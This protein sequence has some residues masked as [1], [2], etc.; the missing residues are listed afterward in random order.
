MYNLY[1][2]CI[3]IIIRQ[4]TK[5]TTTRRYLQIF[6]LFVQGWAPTRYT[7]RYYIINPYKWPTNEW[8]NWGYDL[9][10]WSHLLPL[11]MHHLPG[12]GFRVHRVGCLRRW[13]RRGIRGRGLYPRGWSGWNPGPGGF[14]GAFWSRFCGI[15][16]RNSEM[17]GYCNYSD[18]FFPG[19][20]WYD[21]FVMDFFFRKNISTFSIFLFL[22]T[23]LNIRKR[24][25]TQHWVNFLFFFY[26]DASTFDFESF[27]ARFSKTLGRGL[28]ISFRGKSGSS[29][30]V[31]RK[32]RKMAL[33]LFFWNMGL[34]GCKYYLLILLWSCSFT[35]IL[36]VY[37]CMM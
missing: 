15:G 5:T 29:M 8:G 6:I 24:H 19:R 14:G 25:N 4:T 32:I 10:K 36:P 33:G 26:P 2:W 9:Y 31:V 12:G 22:N 20:V 13:R 35:V 3:A 18:D 28:E 30:S 1:F 27:R 23:K 7:W 17:L 11:A 34:M 21:S 37:C 16:P